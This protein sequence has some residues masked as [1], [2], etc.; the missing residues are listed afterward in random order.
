MQGKRIR[1]SAPAPNAPIAQSSGGPAKAES[2]LERSLDPSEEAGV[3]PD[4][5]G[6]VDLEEAA[7]A[8][9]QRA[10]ELEGRTSLLCGEAVGKEPCRC[11]R[12][13]QSGPAW[14]ALGEGGVEDDL[15]A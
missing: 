10:T 12:R 8:G 5:R 15:A 9:T 4:E 1:S 6:A 3:V 13:E 7:G 2:E 14:C 11:E